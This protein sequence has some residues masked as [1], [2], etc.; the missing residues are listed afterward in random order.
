MN[1]LSPRPL[2]ATLSCLALGAGLMVAGVS[3]TSRPELP[4]VKLEAAHPALFEDVTE[5]AGLQHTYRNGFEA[6]YYAILE[7]LGGGVG[8]LDFDGDGLLDLVVAGGGYYDRA[9]K[10]YP[11]DPKDPGVLTAAL[12]KDPPGIRGYSCKLFRNLGNWKFQD[13]TR[14]VGLD[15]PLLYS[16]GCAIADYDRDGWPDLLITGWGRV[17]LYHNEPVDPADTRKGRRFVEVT[18]KAGLGDQL[19]ST[20]AAW[21]DLDGDGYPD[22]YICH[23]ADWSFANNPPCG[24]YSSGVPRDV[25]P[26]RQFVALPHVLY[27][28]RGDGTFADVS[29]AAGL[30]VRG[31]LGAAGKQVELG[32]GLGVVIAD[33]NADRKPDVYV[34]NDT[35]ENFLYFNRTQAGGGIQLDDKGMDSGTA[36]DDQG[37][38][39]GSMGADIGCYDATGRPSI[40]VTN[41]EGEIHALYRNEGNELFTFRTSA[42]GIAAIGQRYVGFGTAF[43]DIESRGLLDLVIANGHV[44]RHPTKAGLRQQPVL[45]RN[46]GRGNFKACTPEGGPYFRAEHQ[47]RGLAVGDLDNDGRPDLVISHLNDPFVVLRNISG[48]KGERHHWLGLEL[49]GKQNADIVGAR[50]ILDFAGKKQFRFVKGGGSYL[51]SS[52]PRLLFGLGTSERVERLTI[53]WPSGLD[54]SWQGQDLPVDRYWRVL[55]GEKA[56]RPGVSTSAAR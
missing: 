45:L 35:V 40:F 9:R 31:T 41:Y 3:C 19:W 7:S 36:L 4:T 15:T 5:I 49:V 18:V 25:C 11:Q 54:Q 39:N 28:N 2:R 37:M 44:I 1:G 55:E 24:G 27:H 10:D 8:L 51:S 30:R 29:K 43:V 38:A 50:V 47:A 52:D 23:Y 34:A 17:A 20:S 14:E 12:R 56:L 26:P 13:V 6:D 22:L 48:D 21:G 33:L 32:K 53:E 42:A 16:H 46:Q